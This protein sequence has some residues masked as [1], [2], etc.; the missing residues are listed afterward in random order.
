MPKLFRIPAQGKAEYVFCDIECAVLFG[1]D[2]NRS[3]DFYCAFRDAASGNLQLLRSLVSD[4]SGVWINIAGR[5]LNE[6]AKEF[7]T[8]GVLDHSG[9]NTGEVSR[10][11]QVVPQH[12]WMTGIVDQNGHRLTVHCVDPQNGDCR[13]SRGCGDMGWVSPQHGN[14]AV[15]IDPTPV[16]PNIGLSITDTNIYLNESCGS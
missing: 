11:L 5:A 7:P 1:F 6:K 2:M 4:R 9:H 8:E 12:H 3:R 16:V 13:I 15:S 10:V 14:C